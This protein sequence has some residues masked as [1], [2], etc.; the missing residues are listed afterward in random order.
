MSTIQVDRIIPYQS[1]SVTIEGDVTFT[2]AVSTGSFNT[3][4]ASQEAINATLAT[5]GSN[6]FTGQQSFTSITA[7][8]IEIGQQDGNGINIYQNSF[9]QLRFWSG[10]NQTEVGTWVNMQTNPSTG[11]L[12]IA[13]FPHNYHFVHF[14]PFES[15]SRFEGDVKFDASIIGNIQNDVNEAGNAVIFQNPA[16]FSAYYGTALQWR[17]DF[18]NGVSRL[19]LGEKAQ[20]EIYVNAFSG[21]YDNIVK[22][23]A[24]SEGGFFSDWDLPSYGD[25]KWLQI[26]QGGSPTFQRTVDFNNAITLTPQDPLPS[27]AVGQL[28]VSGSNLY[29]YTDQWREVAFV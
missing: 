23:G 15:R 2:G 17:P 8:V 27:G 9:S 21:A 28:A 11:G 29:F 16:F 13:A 1:S 6:T 7:S 24:D 5:T 14:E 3:Y 4:T 26:P 20:S 10:S 12:S 18:N 22:I 19:W 25:A